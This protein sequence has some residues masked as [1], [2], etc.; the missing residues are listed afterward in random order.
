MGTAL[1]EHIDSEHQG[2]V[3]RFIHDLFHRLAVKKEGGGEEMEYQVLVSFLELYNEDLLDLLNPQSKKKC[4]VQIREDV[5]G[6]IYWAGVRE[7]V[8]ET[9]EELV[10][11][12]VKG[13]LGRTTGST[14]MNSVS[15][16]SHAIF[17][18]ILKQRWRQPREEKVIVSKFHFVDL[19]GSERLKR[20]NAQ[21]DRA[22]E[23][24]SINAGLLAL[25]N[26]ISALG[27]E[28]RRSAHVP[29]RDSKL[30]RL[31]Q[32]S[33]GGNSQTLMMACVS[34]S[35]TN[36]AET[37]STLKY[38]N[39]ARNIKNKVAIQQEFAGSSVQ[40]NQLRSQV[41]R[42][43]MEL[44]A[45]KSTQQTPSLGWMHHEEL[46]RLK[47]RVRAMS[48]D[49]CRLTT[50][51]DTLLM[52]RDLTGCDVESSPL[53]GQYQKTIQELRQALS[54]TEERLAFS[55]SVRAPLVQTMATLSPHVSHTSTSHRRRSS[56]KK[57]RPAAKTNTT[58][59]VTFKSTKRSKSQQTTKGAEEEDIESWLKSTLGSIQTSESS[60]LR[61]D[62]KHSIL[63]AKSQIDKALKVLDEFKTKG[64][65]EH[66]EYD[67]DL[68]ADDELFIRLQSDETLFGDM[69]EVGLDEAKA[70]A[71]RSRMSSTETLMTDDTDFIHP[72][73]HK[74]LDQI[75]SDI[76]VSESLVNQLE[77]TELEYLQMRKQFESKIYA[78]RDEILQLRQEASGTGQQQSMHDIRQARMKEE[79]ERVKGRLEQ[80]T[81]EIQQLRKRQQR[82][83][84][85]RRKLERE[86][87]QLESMLQ[88][89]TDESL[90]TAEKVKSLVGILKKA[91]KEGGVLDAQLL[92]NAASL[93]DLGS[94]RKA[95]GRR[96]TTTM[97]KTPASVRAAQK[98]RW[99]DQA[100]NQ[101]IDSKQAAEE[102]RRLVSKRNDL[103]QKKEE[104]L[105]EREHLLQE[106]DKN[107]IPIDRAFR[108][109]IDENIEMI[110]AEISYVNAR[111]QAMNSDAAADLLQDE[112]DFV[113]MSARPVEKRVTF[114]RHEDGDW[115]DMD[116]IEE[117]WTLPARASPEQCIEMLSRILGSMEADELACVMECTLDDIVSLRM[118][119]AQNKMMLQQYEKTTEDLRRTLTVMKK[120]ALDATDDYEKRLKQVQRRR[121]SVHS[122]FTKL[123]YEDSLSDADSAIDVLPED[124]Y[125]HVESLFHKIY[126]EGIADLRRPSTP[127]TL[128]E[129]EL[130][131]YLQRRPSLQQIKM[132]SGA[133]MKPSASPLAGRRGSTSSPEQF[134]QQLLMSE[135]RHSIQSDS[136]PP[137]PTPKPMVETASQQTRRR[138]FSFQQPPTAPS[139]IGQRR[140]SLLREIA[141]QQDFQRE[142][143]QDIKRRSPTNSNELRKSAAA[144]NVFDR[145]SSGHTQ[146]SHAKKRLHAAKNR[147]SSSS[148]DDLR[149][150]WS[151][152]LEKI[153]NVC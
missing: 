106:E 25:G 97:V 86:A 84:E 13:S 48:D 150:Q 75:Q 69:E 19:A 62:A 45:L 76:Q 104:Y 71:Y 52:E 117:R 92:A 68:L 139:P 144:N 30:T 88:K 138:A 4:E 2:I 22:R 95:G 107:M 12:L 136:V 112:E 31:L 28:S 60:G 114:A 101:F 58:K 109:V 145:L 10:K 53:I 35:D 43:T 110:E 124:H 151:D 5:N 39:R 93:L 115:Q 36:F 57:K 140:H 73:F 38:A 67:C 85:T 24:I 18:V 113:D 16:R 29:Y 79:A 21:G 128:A 49:I 96:S 135:R 81:R 134:L 127:S 23:G 74:I 44:Q 146:A 41:A 8:C 131:P 102:M 91:V 47:A 66:T 3:P 149:R 64:V 118:E 132:T 120:T 90:V 83:A 141:I 9:P 133:P 54:E 82:D 27:D 122:S 121:L 1:E 142:F 98:K 153:K 78:L 59:N 6:N 32:D 42:L 108:Q 147:Y 20:T 123:P 26:V 51:R 61:I 14:D 72:H 125:Q 56:S 130:S 15:S 33:L 34:P 143:E 80:H 7:E 77:K 11:N 105:S 99:I 116:A 111:I 40:V 94:W 65:E 50:E 17:S 148:I 89:R 87:K 137:P 55:E 46:D 63:N 37:L 119:E 100:L 126:N 152:E 129:A 103:A 70:S